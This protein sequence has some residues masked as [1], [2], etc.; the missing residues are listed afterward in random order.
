MKNNEDER[1]E[2]Q[3]LSLE[4]VSQMLGCRSALGR[5]VLEKEMKDEMMRLEKEERTRKWLNDID[6]SR[7][8]QAPRAPQAVQAVS[9]FIVSEFRVLTFA[10]L[11]ETQCSEFKLLCASASF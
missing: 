3:V 8:M 1:L 6:A 11:V 10:G 4:K 2:R 5:Q 7:R 9:A